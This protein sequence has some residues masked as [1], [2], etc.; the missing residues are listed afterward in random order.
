MS[1]SQHNDSEIHLLLYVSVGVSFVLFSGIPL[2]DRSQYS[3]SCLH[4]PH[5]LVTLNKAAMNIF[6][7]VF[8][9]TQQFIFFW[10][11]ASIP[12]SGMAGSYV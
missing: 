4:F 2:M 5:I 7:H 12:R 11:G 8:I 10:G 9:W 3:F 6:V 1:L